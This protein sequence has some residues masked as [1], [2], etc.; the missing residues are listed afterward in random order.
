MFISLS[1]SARRYHKRS[2]SWQT[3]SFLF[4]R[5]NLLEFSL[6]VA[7]TGGLER[8]VDDSAEEL[9]S[10]EER[11]FLD[12]EAVYSIESEGNGFWTLWI[13]FCDK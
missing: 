9:F 13:I 1:I 5:Q 10:P 3:R 12:F 2:L 7:N 6:S 8:P 4:S 11:V